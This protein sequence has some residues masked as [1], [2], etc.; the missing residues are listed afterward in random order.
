MNINYIQEFIKEKLFKKDG[1]LNTKRI[2]CSGK[3]L[4]KYYR[5]EYCQILKLTEFL[6][7]SYESP[8]FSQRIWH[9]FYNKFYLIKCEWCE[10]E[11][12]SFNWF[13]RG[14][15]RFCCPKCASYKS[16]IK[17][18]KTYDKKSEEEKQKVRNKQRETH[19]NKTEFKKQE[20]SRKFKKT[21]VEK[22]GVD[23]PSK[24]SEMMNK[25]IKR[26]FKLKENKL[27]SGKIINL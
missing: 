19:L 26:R 5:D 6:D 14:Y 23:H 9:I 4:F 12:V 21:N 24:N 17:R 10:T 18:K 2:E 25:I 3:W 11:V 15:F 13:T 8:S 1:K 16:N 27:P 7:S 22:F 20:K